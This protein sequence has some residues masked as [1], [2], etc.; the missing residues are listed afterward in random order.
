[1]ETVSQSARAAH[2]SAAAARSPPHVRTGEKAANAFTDRCTLVRRRSLRSMYCTR[3]GC[4]FEREWRECGCGAEDHFTV[5]QQTD[6]RLS[7][8]L[9]RLLTPL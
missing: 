3:L 9:T 8:L 7:F 2:V 6:L 1:M 4:D 5:L